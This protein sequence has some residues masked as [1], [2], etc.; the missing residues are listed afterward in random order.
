MSKLHLLLTHHWVAALAFVFS[1]SASAQQVVTPSK[2]TRKVYLDQ[3][4][5][6]VARCGIHWGN[7]VL[8]GDDAILAYQINIEGWMVP[9]TKQ[10]T[11]VVWASLRTTTVNKAGH[12]TTH[13]DTPPSDIYLFIEQ[14]P[15]M[16]RIEP[17]PGAFP[18]NWFGGAIAAGGL[19]GDSE[20]AMAPTL[21]MMKRIPMLVYL[22]FDRPSGEKTTL[23][24]TTI[25]DLP[26]EQD[27]ALADCLVRGVKRASPSSIRSAHVITKRTVFVLGAGANVPYGLGRDFT[28]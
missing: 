13:V 11:T 3:A 19:H 28:G 5:D 10:S 21:A 4:N 16:Y 7:L 15:T 24:F 22:V 20:K 17:T 25:N 2:V 18:A 27:A 12:G 23:A 26:K 6:A 8:Q 9:E 14:N 1:A